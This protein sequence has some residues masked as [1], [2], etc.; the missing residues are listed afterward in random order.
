MY[1]DISF[2]IQ[3]YFYFF[4]DKIKIKYLFKKMCA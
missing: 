4:K 1:L 2:F 3:R